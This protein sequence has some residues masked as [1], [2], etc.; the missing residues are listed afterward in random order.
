MEPDR[1][2]G[3]AAALRKALAAQAQERASRIR[4]A[5]AEA[6]RLARQAAEDARKRAEAAR[7][8]WVIPVLRYHL[9]AGFGDV[10]LWSSSHT[11]QDFAA[12]AGTPVR[13]VGDGR[14]VF[15]G[16]DGAYGNK[17]VVEHPD[18]TLTW[19]AHLLSIVRNGGAV[20]AGD[21]IARVGS[22]GNSTGNHLHLEV[23]PA[24]GSAIA[25]LPWLRAR[26]VD[27]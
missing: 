15:A 12:P 6:V 21:V 11:G 17:V 14:I 16:W 25:P 9:T 4:T 13:S 10:G 3:F 18:G 26:G 2:A 22:T 23:R 7:P 20:R 19:Y 24:G 5:R 27:V 1:R 8:K